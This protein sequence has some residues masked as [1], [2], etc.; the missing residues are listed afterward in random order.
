MRCGEFGSASVA[1][2]VQLERG[3]VSGVQVRAQASGGGAVRGTWAGALRH[4]P[5]VGHG[6]RWPYSN[7]PLLMSEGRRMHV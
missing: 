4:R 7:K 3:A 6:K 1:G 2:C 5:K